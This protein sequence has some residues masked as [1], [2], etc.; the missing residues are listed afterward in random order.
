MKD[1]ETLDLPDDIFDLDPLTLDKHFLQQPK[2]VWNYGKEL[3]DAKDESDR[4]KS[5]MDLAKAEARAEITDNPESFGLSKTTESALNSAVELHPLLCKA[6]TRL[7]KRKHRVDVLLA[8]LSALEHRKR[9]LEGLV[10]LH[11][12]QYFATPKADSDGQEFLNAQQKMSRR[13]TKKKE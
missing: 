1:K 8:F 3:A 2:L 6:R 7:Q 10:S 4:A 11:G 12:Q 9:A 13:R 5:R